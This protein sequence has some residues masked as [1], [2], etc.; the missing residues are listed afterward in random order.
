MDFA[1]IG[2][3][4]PHWKEITPMKKHDDL[5][6]GV[7]LLRMTRCAN[8]IKIRCVLHHFNIVFGD[9]L[10]YNDIQCGIMSGNI[11]FI[12]CVGS[13]LW[14]REK[15]KVDCQTVVNNCVQYSNIVYVPLVV[16]YI[17]VLMANPISFLSI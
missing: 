12:V 15:V 10:T 11:I 7:L 4:C 16:T 6:L 5:R 8:L 13:Q 3:C 1:W 14:D 9:T 17:S 2:S